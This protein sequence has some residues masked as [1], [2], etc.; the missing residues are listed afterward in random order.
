[1][2]GT[3][4]PDILVARRHTVSLTTCSRI[5][6]NLHVTTRDQIGEV[7]NS[8]NIGKWTFLLFWQQKTAPSRIQPLNIYNLCSWGLKSSLTSRYILHLSLHQVQKLAIPYLIYQNLL[9]SLIAFV[10]LATISPSFLDK[11]FTWSG[12]GEKFCHLQSNEAFSAN[13]IVEYIIR[14]SQ[15]VMFESKNPSFCTLV[16]DFATNSIPD[17]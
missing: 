4:A 2:H 13:I 6:E 9:R 16:F 8:E 17:R 12:R 7:M 14:F 3:L 11:L 15:I 1:M 5:Q 10:D